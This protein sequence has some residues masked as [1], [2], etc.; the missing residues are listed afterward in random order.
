[1]A[2]TGSTLNGI[3]L[4][5]EL[6]KYAHLYRPIDPRK[7]TKAAETACGGSVCIEGDVDLTGFIDDDLHTVSFKHMKVSKPIVSMRKCV[8]AGNELHITEEGGYIKNRRSGKTVQLVERCGVYFFKL[9][10]LPPDQLT[11]SDPANKP[12]SGFGRQA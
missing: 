3:G 8:K 11:Q 4:V 9:C 12:I 7:K 1:M 10:L 6:P 2:D 5:K